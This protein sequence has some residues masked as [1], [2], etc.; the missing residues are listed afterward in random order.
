[1]SFKTKISGASFKGSNFIDVLFKDSELYNLDFKGVKGSVFFNKNTLIDSLHVDKNFYWMSI[2]DVQNKML[3]EKSD[4]LI[5]NYTLRQH[6][7]K[8][9][10]AKKDE[11]S[12]NYWS[13]KLNFL[14]SKYLALDTMSKK[15]IIKKL[16]SKSDFIIRDK[17]YINLLEIVNK[18][19]KKNH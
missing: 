12:M 3:N 19:S 7:I 5:K 9:K 11:K 16:N 6:L 10:E 17:D 13:S 8:L 15:I 18:Q 2:K 1:V 4:F 14:H